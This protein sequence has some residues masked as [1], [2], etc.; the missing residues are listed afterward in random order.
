M[1]HCLV[2]GLLNHSLQRLVSDPKRTSVRTS[3]WPR[4]PFSSSRTLTKIVTT[5]GTRLFS[6]S[7]GASASWTSAHL[8]WALRQDQTSCSSRVEPSS[9]LVGTNSNFKEECVDL[10]TSLVALRPWKTVSLMV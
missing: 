7:F 9:S 1:E 3:S 4:E 5:P 6:R 8:G 10:T 2:G